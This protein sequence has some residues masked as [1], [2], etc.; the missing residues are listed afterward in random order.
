MRLLNP[1]ILLILFGV[2]YTISIC[3]NLNTDR[4]L[5]IWALDIYFLFLSN[6]YILYIIFLEGL[7]SYIPKIINIIL[8]WAARLKYSKYLCHLIRDS[9]VSSLNTVMITSNIISSKLD[10]ISN[11]KTSINA[12]YFCIIK[13]IVYPIQL[14][15]SSIIY[16]ISN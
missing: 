9:L 16:T 6:I 13:D 7:R 5:I 12:S 1:I 4:I 14:P 2:I 11:A 10:S 8:T 15:V 3:T